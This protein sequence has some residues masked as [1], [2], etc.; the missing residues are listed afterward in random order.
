MPEIFDAWLAEA[1]SQFVLASNNILT[2]SITKS[3]LLI[4]NNIW[5][6]NAAIKNQYS[7]YSKFIKQTKIKFQMNI[8]VVICTHHV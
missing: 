8:L 6:S 3:L 4:M 2:N 5:D 1:H 7:N